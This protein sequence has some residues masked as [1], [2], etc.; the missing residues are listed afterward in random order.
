MKKRKNLKNNIVNKSNISSEKKITNKGIF[1]FFIK[2]TVGLFILALVAGAVVTLFNIKIYKS[3]DDF[4]HVKFNSIL[5]ENDDKYLLYLYENSEVCDFIEP[6]ILEYS[7]KTTIPIYVVNMSDED[8]KESAK[9]TD[10]YIQDKEKL[11]VN[12]SPAMIL[13]EDGN[14]VDYRENVE[15][16][17]G[18][19][20]RFFT[21]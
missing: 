18:L 1:K 17:M 15:E 10:F 5:S 20:G 8:N 19:I 11:M 6:T 4:N 7:K 3:I 16:V 12:L 14:I 13:V 2:V 21:N 9:D